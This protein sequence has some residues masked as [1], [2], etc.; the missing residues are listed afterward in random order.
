VRSLF[1]F[2]SL[3]ALGGCRGCGEDK[4]YT[5]FIVGSTVEL[6]SAAP[7]ASAPD[8]DEQDAGPP[9][10]VARPALQAPAAAKTWVLDGKEMKAPEG[11]VFSSGLFADFDGD[12]QSEIVAW[13]V[14]ATGSTN[15][16][17]GELWLY[18]AN[19]KIAELPG[20]VPNAPSCAQTATLSQTGPKSVTLDASAKCQDAGLP[21]APVRAVSVIQPLS[22]RTTSIALRVADPAPGETLKIS[23]DSSDQDGDGRDDVRVVIGVSAT[24]SERPASAELRW[25]DRAAGVSRAVSEP[26]ASIARAASIE[27]GRSKKKTL[28]ASVGQGVGNVRRLI[29]TLCA[30]A[31]VPRVF[32]E[33]GAP[34]RCGDLSSTT[35]RLLA[36]EVQSGVA[37]GET[38]AALGALTRDG[39][40]VR[41][42]SDKERERLEKS[43]VSSLVNLESP[44]VVAN[45]AKVV[46]HGKEPRWSPLAFE[47]SGSLLV[48][49]DPNLSRVALTGESQDLAED[50]SLK[51][52][53]LGLA[54]TDGVRVTG[55]APACDRSEV[56]LTL[57]APTA[58]PEVT[59]LLAPRPGACKG[60][61]V[62]ALGL[63]PLGFKDEKLE[64]IVAGN[65]VGPTVSKGEA[66]LRPR[67]L[68]SARSP[69]GRLLVAPVSLGLAVIGGDK[70]ELWRVGD[71][72][73]LGDCVV[74]DQAK[75]VACVEGS[76]VKLWTRP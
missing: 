11:R 20:F 72:R 2:L 74:A 7:S 15:V 14:P 75:A 23:V 27:M 52:W 24:G 4:P 28:A 22:A 3:A 59:T 41:R 62:S 45:T 8:A 43:V 56:L 76:S 54:R 51:S 35:D 36:A 69:D 53:S 40:Y 30:E 25:L 13:T 17:A 55:L 42:A 68:G 58:P 48:A 57:S 33:D 21:R 60:G 9:K 64:A 26:S 34:F 46:A 71:A 6:A 67:V 1:L 12:G 5:P 32:A 39:W 19:K 63:A 44:K 70:P 73:S 50:P 16:S 38:L 10:F 18:P 61:A 37:S 65:H 66:T 31:G 47:T 49:G 29:G